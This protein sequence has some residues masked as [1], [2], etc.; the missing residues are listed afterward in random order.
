M[1]AYS[2]PKRENDPHSLPDVEVFY[3][4]TAEAIERTEDS[5]D[6]YEAGWY[7]HSCLPGCLPDSEPMG[8]FA[9]QTEALTDAQSDEA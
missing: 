6:D 3:L 1:Q 4:T 9:T 2:N 5:G 8:P 7:W